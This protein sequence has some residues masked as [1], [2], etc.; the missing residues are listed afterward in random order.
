[1]SLR[2]EPA[3]GRYRREAGVFCGDPVTPPGPFDPTP[4]T[5]ESRKSGT[6]PG[7]PSSNGSASSLGSQDSPGTPQPLRLTVF[8]AARALR[9][10]SLLR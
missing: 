1:M 6:A 5:T 4:G 2:S 10:T 9:P 3:D 8:F 7:Q